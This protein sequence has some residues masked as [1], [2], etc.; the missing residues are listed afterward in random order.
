MWPIVFHIN[1][2]LYGLKSILTLYSLSASPT[3]IEVIPRASFAFLHKYSTYFAQLG[4]APLCIILESWRLFVFFFFL[5]ASSRKELSSGVLSTSCLL[6]NLIQGQVI[7]FL[8]CFFFHLAKGTLYLRNQW[9]TFYSN[10]HQTFLW[11]RYSAIFPKM[12]K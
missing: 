8:Q 10:V 9:L 4:F 1:I 3:V 5:S 7:L 11:A 12:M 2:T 6:W